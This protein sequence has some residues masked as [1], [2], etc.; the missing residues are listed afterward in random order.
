MN[1]LIGLGNADGVSPD[2]AAQI[3]YTKLAV[4]LKKRQNIQYR[5][6][7]FL[8][9]TVFIIQVFVGVGGGMGFSFTFPDAGQSVIHW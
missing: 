7:R 3:Q 5:P 2:A 8:Q 6:N 4:R 9:P 1:V